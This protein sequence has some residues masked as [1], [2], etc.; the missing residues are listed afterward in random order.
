MRRIY[1]HVM[2]RLYQA[3][4]TRAL[5]LHFRL[6]EKAEKFFRKIRGQA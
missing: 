4:S 1:W 5:S 3:R 2:G 6:A